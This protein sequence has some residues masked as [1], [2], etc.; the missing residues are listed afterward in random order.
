LNLKI[1][2]VYWTAKKEIYLLGAIAQEETV[3]PYC[4]KCGNELPEETKY[5]PV[6]GTPVSAEEVPAAPVMSTVSAAPETSGLQLAFWWERFVAWLID[7]IIVDVVLSIFLSIIGFIGFLGGLPFNAVFDIARWGPLFGF[8]GIVIF[9]YWMFMEV[10][11]GQSI[12]KM[13]MRI[14]VTRTNGSPISM[15]QAAVESLGKAFFPL[16]VLDCVL[17]WILYPKRR[18]RLF[19]YLSQTIVVKVT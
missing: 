6:C 4:R 10:A 18:Q 11:N 16:L 8:N 13:V 3:M 1:V 15:G 5:C 17:G 19:N 14:K 9:F 12:G 7:V 2:K